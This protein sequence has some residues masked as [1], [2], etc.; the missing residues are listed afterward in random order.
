MV[1]KSMVD[2]RPDTNIRN[3]KDPSYNQQININRYPPLSVQN[4]CPE[5]ENV[6]R[7]N[8]QMYCHLIAADALSDSYTI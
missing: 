2:K 7:L 4:Y 3:T 6:H 8:T 5:L 1:F